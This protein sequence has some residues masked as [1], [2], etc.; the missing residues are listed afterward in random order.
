MRRSLMIALPISLLAGA[1][2]L[3]AQTPDAPPP[4]PGTTDVAR[5]A[6]GTYAP[7][8]AHT[9]IGWRVSHFG[10]NDYFGQFG[11]VTGTLTLDPVNP[12]NA[13]VDLTIPIASLSSVSAGLNTH[14]LGGD[15][16]DATAHPTARFVSTSVIVEGT[17]ATISGN[18]TIR[19]T[20][21]P[22]VLAA[23]FVGAGTNPYNRKETVGF[24]ATTT[25]Q[26]S[27]FGMGYGIPLVS[28]AVDLT[29]SVAF[30][31]Q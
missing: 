29:I 2:A 25:I 23:R 24:H 1:T 28:D 5:I 22:V 15:F 17:T 11:N 20:T 4:I 6:A 7:D 14:M 13:A 21:Q 19:G 9:L 27:A 8:A 31:K 16:F 10:F 26:R 30:E 3:Y 12:Q 18:L